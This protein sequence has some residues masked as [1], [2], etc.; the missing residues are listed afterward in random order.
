MSGYY[1][2]DDD[3]DL[4]I[5]R[6]RAT[7]VYPARRQYDEPGQ[8]SF[9]RG[10]SFHPPRRLHRASTLPVRF[11][12]ER[13]VERVIRPEDDRRS[14]RVALPRGGRTEV[15]RRFDR[16]VEP[17]RVVVGE[18]LESGRTRTVIYERERDRPR[19]P[20]GSTRRAPFRQVSVDDVTSSDNESEHRERHR[21][22]VV[23]T[24]PDGDPDAAVERERERAEARQ[25]RRME[26]DDEVT[27]LVASPSHSPVRVREREIESETSDVESVESQFPKKGKTRMPA[28]L[29]STRAI[30]DL[31]YPYEVEVGSSKNQLTG[32]SDISRAIRSPFARLWHVKISTSSLT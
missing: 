24:G 8:R 12:D 13:I 6:G 5:H 20:E 22:T 25:K 28:R 31:G 2:S 29:V 32:S 17:E 19:E 11:E 3:L 23:G 1:D 9:P 18:P 21:E 10:P 26:Q 14:T 16:Y 30:I 7:P 4:R 27:P 15:D